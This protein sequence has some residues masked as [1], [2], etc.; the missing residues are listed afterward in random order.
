MTY[1]RILVAV[2]DSPAGLE[3]ARAAVDLAG[4][5]GAA[6]RAITVH[7]DH[8]VTGALGGE[9]VSTERRIA[10]SGRALLSWVADLAAAR[11]VPC[12]TVEREGEPFRR[13]LEEADTY[14]A[15]LIVM[16][17]SD[18]RGPSSPYL[19]SATAHVL[20]FAV[21]PVLVVPRAEDREPGAAP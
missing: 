19:G 3:A 1:D 18:R 5:H 16:G 2:D 10:N 20:E 7:V 4:S 14:D 12:D 21:R 17:R 6:V 9:P 8:A 15:D 11:H 13:I